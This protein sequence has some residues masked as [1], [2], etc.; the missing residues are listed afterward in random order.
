MMILLC[1]LDVPR[2]LKVNLCFAQ[3]PWVEHSHLEA[4]FTRLRFQKFCFDIN[5]T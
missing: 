2:Y 5:G 1:E 3:G 4:W